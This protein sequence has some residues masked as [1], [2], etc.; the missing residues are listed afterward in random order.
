[1]K[2]V[3]QGEVS[4]K[5][6]DCMRAAIASILEVHLQAVP[7]LTRTNQRKWFSVLYY[8]FASYEY[9]YS[10]ML[11]PGH[12]KRRL[13]KRHS[14]NGFYLATVDSRTYKPEEKITHMVVMDR[15]WIVA[16]DPHPNKKWKGENLFGNP[17]LRHIYQF[18]KMNKTD[19]RYWHYL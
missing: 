14:I 13:L 1:M 18:R 15:N 4:K 2:K 3:N 7:H 19:E 17:E 8:F 12:S 6:G 11:Y 10:G 16:H 9:L 5:T